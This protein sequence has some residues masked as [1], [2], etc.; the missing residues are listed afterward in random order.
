MV[1]LA[2]SAQDHPAVLE[3]RWQIQARAKQW[4]ACIGIAR[5]ITQV[6]PKD[7]FGWI[8]L[9][10]SLHELKRTQ[11][12]WD[13]LIAVADQ[14]P[15]DLTIRY[16]LACYACQMGDLPEARRRLQNAL[17]LGHKKETK[18]M[19]VEDLD[20]KPLWPEIAGM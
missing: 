4:E 9:S 14:F 8:Q 10:Y 13:N 15:K 20:Q 17:A 19:A 2:S 7:A 11:E 5:A 6:A 3:L 18:Q 1:G 12:A 16:N